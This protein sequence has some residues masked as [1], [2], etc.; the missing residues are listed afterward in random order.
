MICLR[1]WGCLWGCCLRTILNYLNQLII[2]MILG[3]SK[4]IWTW[5]W[6]GL[7]RTRCLLILKSVV[8]FLFPGG[9]IQSL[10]TTTLKIVRCREVKDLGVIFQDNFKFNNHYNYLINKA[11]R[12]LGFVMRNSKDFDIQ[13]TT[14]L[15]TS[16]VRPHLEYASNIWSPNCYTHSNEIEKVQKRFLRYIYIKR[17]NMYPTMI[18]YRSMLEIFHLT[19]L[20]SRRRTHAVIFIYN[21]LNNLKYADCGLINSIKF[22]V[23]KI[24]LRVSEFNLFYIEGGSPSPFTFM[25]TI[26][27]DMLSGNTIPDMFSIKFGE[28][29]RILL[30]HQETN[31]VW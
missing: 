18:S 22:R 23:P 14:R 25:L 15:Y 7:R 31:L 21:I 3:L 27:N 11:Y 6:T 16:L 20:A 24:R 26:C 28:L 2:L 19:S 5:L 4:L 30:V 1:V 9:S 10:K 17:N 12:I 8:L 13:S 29:R